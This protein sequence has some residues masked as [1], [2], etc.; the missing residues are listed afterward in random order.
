LCEGGWGKAKLTRVR[1]PE[2]VLYCLTLCF[3][4]SC[5]VVPLSV[6]LP[7]LI[8]LCVEADYICLASLVCQN[9]S[10]E[11]F[12]ALLFVNILE[13]MTG[14]SGCRSNSRQD[15]RKAPCT[16]Q[17]VFKALHLLEQQAVC[18]AAMSLVHGTTTSGPGCPAGHRWASLSVVCV[19]EAL[20]YCS[21]LLC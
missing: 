6:V 4:A 1:L 19:V 2:R 10:L 9:T 16:L 17:D 13:H 11:K 21:L 7:C 14:T 5:C 12:V 8:R 18:T 3:T 20:L 15:K